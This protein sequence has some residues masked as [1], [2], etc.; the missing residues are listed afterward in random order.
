MVNRGN[1]SAPVINAPAVVLW[2]I[3]AFLLIHLVRSFLPEDADIWTILTFAFIPARYAYAS[4]ELPGGI[5]ADVWTFVS[6]MFLHGGWAHVLVNSFWMLAFGTLVARRL[7]TT[8]FLLVSAFSG[9][10][11]AT[12]HLF[13]YW[14]Q[15]APVIG[16]SAAISGQ[17]AAAIRIM[18]ADPGG[19]FAA[20]RRN[21]R[22]VPILSLRDTFRNRGALMFI[23][24]WLAI[25]LIF[26]VLSFGVSGPGETVAWEAHIGGFFAGLLI[27]GP[28]DRW[29]RAKN[30]V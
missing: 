18:F 6:H 19:M 11:G 30:L 3:G 22:Y 21:P 16:A 15:L 9:I 4:S 29:V 12:L 27:F 23:G 17:M 1:S 2:L 13:L 26:G 8:G 24:V 7:G 25:N 5:G 20:T 10:A 28:V 14:G